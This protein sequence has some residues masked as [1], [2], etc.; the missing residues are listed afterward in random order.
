MREVRERREGRG[1]GSV[2][3]LREEMDEIERRASRQK[4][5]SREQKS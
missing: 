2:E 5:E 3:R 4:V 1:E